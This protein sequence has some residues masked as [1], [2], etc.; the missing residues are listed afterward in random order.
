MK[1]LKIIIT[2]AIFIYSIGSI[3]A[4]EYRHFPQ[5]ALRSVIVGANSEAKTGFL[6]L[7]PYNPTILAS[8]SANGTISLFNSKYPEDAPTI[9][10]GHTKRISEI[11]FHPGNSDA[12]ASAS[13]DNTVRLWDIA[14][15]RKSPET[16]TLKNDNDWPRALAFNPNDSTKIAAATSDTIYLWNSAQEIKWEKDNQKNPTI[17]TNE[18]GHTWINSLAFNSKYTTRLAS[19]SFDG[20]DVRVCNTASPKRAHISLFEDKDGPNSQENS[21]YI[22]SIAFSRD[23][24]LFACAASDKKIRL[25]RI[26]QGEKI[27]ETIRKTHA[28]RIQ[29]VLFNS[30]GSRLASYDHKTICVYDTAQPQKQPQTLTDP[31]GAI[32]SVAFDPQDS[33]RLISASG[34]RKVSFWKI[35]NS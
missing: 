6:V 32:S 18:N 5:N 15:P 31:D 11:L 25:W 26:L 28:H 3:N 27:V 7:N 9:L 24:A 8:A 35:W 20:E 12:L 23:G 33:S 2:Q 4:T 30:D 17:I 21:P 1:I 13:L 16:L 22:D 29:K 34:N 19:A 10:S 14:Q